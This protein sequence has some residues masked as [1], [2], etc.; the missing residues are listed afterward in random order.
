M[1]ALREDVD[2]DEVTLRDF[3]EAMEKVKPSIT[4]DMDTWY[5]NFSKRFRRERAAAPTAIA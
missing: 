2:A 4:A 1:N 5:Q 3:K